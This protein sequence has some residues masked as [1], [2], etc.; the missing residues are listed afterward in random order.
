MFCSR[1]A[2]R[3][4]LTEDFSHFLL[5][6]YIDSE[7]KLKIMHWGQVSTPEWLMCMRVCQGAEVWSEMGPTV[8]LSQLNCRKMCQTARVSANCGNVHVFD[9]TDKRIISLSFFNLVSAELNNIPNYVVIRNT[10]AVL[11]MYPAGVFWLKCYI[12]VFDTGECSG[13]LR[14]LVWG[15][16]QHFFRD[17]VIVSILEIP[18]SC[19][20][21][22]FGGF[23]GMPYPKNIRLS[24]FSSSR[25]W[26]SCPQR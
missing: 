23:G 3:S 14:R 1:L 15:N 4:W 18:R 17:R 12:S 11:I 21:V 6:P 20:L 16:T 5:R 13:S 8:S 25:T 9:F 26:P 24:S 22:P 10:V 19:I 7:M 2:G